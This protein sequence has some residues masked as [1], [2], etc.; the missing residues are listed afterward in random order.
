MSKPLNGEDVKLNLVLHSEATASR[1]LS[2]NLKVQAMKYNGFPSG[3]IQTAL[4]DKTLLPGQDLLIPIVVQFSEY[5]KL[6][7]DSDVLKISAVVSDKQQPSLVFL[8]ENN[9]VLLDPPINIKLLNE[10]RVRSEVSLEVVFLNPVKETLKDC[11]LTLSGSGLWK[12]PHT[13]RLSDLGPHSR[14]RSNVSFVPYKTGLQTLV[15]NFDCSVFRNIKSS[16]SFH[17][18]E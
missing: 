17:V 4:K 14:L 3:I 6:M 7:L 5:W 11:T 13:V 8:A 2:I 15:A 18:K 16:C 10:A 9:V 1:S 12:E